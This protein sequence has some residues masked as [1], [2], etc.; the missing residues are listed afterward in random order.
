MLRLNLM[1]PCAMVY[2][3]SMARRTWEGC[4]EP[5]VHAEPEEAQIPNSSI[6]RRI[7]SPSINSKLMFIV[8]G[9]RFK[10]SL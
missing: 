10:D 8:L 7:P 4:R 1:E 2:G 5:D 3:I 9:R 6:I